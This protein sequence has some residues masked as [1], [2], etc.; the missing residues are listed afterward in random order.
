MAESLPSAPTLMQTLIGSL[1]AASPSGSFFLFAISPMM[2]RAH[3]GG[4]V[5]EV[6]R[7]PVK[8]NS[9]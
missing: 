1:G 5:T 8:A 6:I 2:R 7:L 4:P 3:G 9:Q